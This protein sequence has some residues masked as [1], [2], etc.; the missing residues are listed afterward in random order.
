M[1][2]S[3]QAE[4]G[5]IAIAAEQPA[6]AAAL[7]GVLDRAFGPG[8]LAKTSERVREQGARHRYDLS[9][10]AVEDGAPIGCCRM[11]DINVGE[12]A[13]LFLGPLAVDPLNQHA[14]LGARLV[15]AALA[16]SR[17][18]G[19]AVI[20][21]GAAAFFQPFGFVRIPEGRVTLPGPVD[22]QRLLWMALTP[23]ALDGLEGAVSAPP[24]ASRS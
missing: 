9:R 19:K 13:A 10:V 6:Q 7:E 22:P 8:R 1:N 2:A 14:G 5:S 11:H 4:R 23:G 3:V 15:E 18:E 21:V 20:L 17:S 24:A 12:R 16:A